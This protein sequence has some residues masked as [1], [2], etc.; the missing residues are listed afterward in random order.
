M[1]SSKLK[2][3]GEFM[4]PGDCETRIEE[5]HL[6]RY[7]FA[8]RF[9]TNKRVLDVACGYGYGSRIIAASLPKS[10]LGIDINHDLIE[11]AIAE[12]GNEI[13]DFKNGSITDL[14]FKE[15]YDVAI[16]F[17]TIEHVLEYEKAI[18]SLYDALVPGGLLLIS[19]PNR[20]VTSPLAKS[21]S[22]PPG[23]PFHVQ[24]FTPEELK[25]FLTAAGFSEKTFK[26]YGQR[27]SLRYFLPSFLK[28]ITNKLLGD[29]SYK[30]SPWP[31]R[32]RV[33]QPAYF[34]L[35]VRKSLK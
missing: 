19:S 22:D 21:I 25:N 14:G 27:L 24:E 7:N 29:P 6:R 20:P 17:E 30:N 4:V 26:T 8:S 35:I 10:Y 18:T 12:Y 32:Y 34:V 15:K 16:C 5:D 9:C 31:R 3:T 33:R 1:S 23:N 2:F 11:N 13:V 28:R